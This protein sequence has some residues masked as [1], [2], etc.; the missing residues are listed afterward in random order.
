MSSGARLAWLAALVII[1]AAVGV[2]VRWL[3]TPAP[4]PETRLDV[5]TPPTSDPTF[6]ISPDGR[7]LVFVAPSNGQRMIWLRPLDTTAARPLPGTEDGTNP[8]WSPDNKSIGFFAAG[9]LK[10]LDLAGGAP[11]LLGAL[12]I[13]GHGG[14][15]AV[16]GIILYKRPGGEGGLVRIPASGGEG[17]VVT[18][19][20]QGQSDVQ[21]QFL[22]DGRQFIFFRNGLDNVR[23]IYLGSLDDAQ[24]TRLTDADAAG[25]FIVAGWLTYIRQGTLVARRF[26]VTHHALSGDPVSIAL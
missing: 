3:R 11:Q 19:P 12:T 1:S 25:R 20:Q 9:Q 16:S 6:A 22:P 17:A 18:K 14:A 7:Q 15:W 13:P 2:G 8:F 4:T 21:P 26:D 5:T 23:G 10:R 24:V